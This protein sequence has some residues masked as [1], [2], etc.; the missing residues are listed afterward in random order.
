VVSEENEDNV[1][2]KKGSPKKRSSPGKKQATPTKSEARNNMS[3]ARGDTLYTKALDN[4]MT[5]DISASRRYSNIVPRHRFEDV[6]VKKT[7]QEVVEERL[8]DLYKK[9]PF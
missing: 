1:L 9:F 2:A 7:E 5:M 8:D 4:S 6:V 3:P